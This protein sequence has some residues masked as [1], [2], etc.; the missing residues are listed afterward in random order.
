MV[1]FNYYT[2]TEIVFGENSEYEVANLIKVYKGKKVLVHYGGKSALE[3]GLLDRI[4]EALTANE[5]TYVSLGGVVAN[6][7]LSKI[8]EGITL[9]KTEKVDFVLAV[10][11]GSVIDSSKAIAVGALSKEPIWSFVGNIDIKKALPVGVVL[12][13]AAAGSEMSSGAVIT[14]DTNDLKRDFGG[15]ALRPVF[16]ILNPELTYTLPTYQ[17]ACGVADIIMHTVERYFT[18]KTSMEITDQISNVL[19]QTVMRH[20]LVLLDE[21]TNYESRAEIMW[22]GSLSH[23]GL[24]GARASGGDWACHQ[25]GHELSAK[26]G[27][28]HGAS[29][30]AL[31]PTWARYVS[32][33]NKERFKKFAIEVMEVD[34]SDKTSS[35]I[36]DQ[37][38]LKL[39]D[40]FKK[41][42][43]PTTLKALDKD[44]NEE[45]I[46]DMALKAT[47]NNTFNPGEI[48]KLHYEDIINIMS[49][50]NQ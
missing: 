38:I 10:G 21:P 47:H 20:A 6:P 32:G 19:I 3:S 33:E 43:L 2:P 1:K 49:K 27:V 34:P 30:T 48:K 15:R 50:A 28:A 44:I 14:N 12:T 45:D 11:G 36:I 18:N 31:W 39:E 23:N 5:I 35:E 26:Y 25:M 4:Y 29:L 46:K 9:A 13:I 17:T 22:S 40:F 41:L 7:V 16:A 42:D 8:E 24:T 37:G